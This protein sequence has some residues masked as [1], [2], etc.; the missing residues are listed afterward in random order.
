MIK[1]EA[2]IRIDKLK[3]EINHHRYLYH[4]LDTQEISDAALDSLKHELDKLEE[5]FPD[6][7]TLDSP[8]QRVGGVPLD[9]FEKV[10]HKSLMISLNDAFSPDE[11]LDWQSR[12]Q[13]LSPNTRLDYYAELKMDGFAISLI[14]K[15]G[16]LTQGS[17]RGD[18]AVGED[19]TKNLKT[20]ESIPL[21][22]EIY[23]GIHK[24]SVDFL[25][26]QDLRGEIEVRGEVYMTKQAF[27]KINKER[28]RKGEAI[29]AN[30]RNTAA[31]SIRQLNPEIAQSRELK[32]MAYALVTDLGQETHA[33]EHE[34]LG[35]L[36]FKAGMGEHCKNLEEVVKFWDK[37][38]KTRERL[39]FEIDGVV[40]NVNDNMLFKKF[41][42]VG[43]AP[44]GAIA[45]KFHGRE[46][47]TKVLDIQAQ[48][49]R[50]GALT[51][52]AILEPVEVGGVTIGRASL[53][54]QDEID[55]LDV[56]IGDTVIVRRAGDVIPDV[57]K[58]F[59]KLR[60][61]HEKKFH[62]PS[63]CPV[64][65]SKVVR[66]EGEVA[67]RCSNPE[68]GAV[69]RERLYH[70]VSKKAFNIVGLGPQRLDQLLDEGLIQDAA[71]IFDL[72]E[73]DVTSLE[74]FADR[75]A[76]NLIDSINNSKTITLPRLI[77]ALGILHIGEETAVDLA[78]QFGDI[79]KL[80]EVSFNDL[81]KVRD[82]GPVVAKSI[83][84]WFSKNKNLDFIV[85][86]KKAGVVIGKMAPIKVRKEFIGKTFVF[87]GELIQMTRDEA[88]NKVREF[89]GEVAGSVSANTDYVVAGEN[90]GSKYDKAMELGVKVI[91]EKDFL[92]M[93]K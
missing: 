36:G 59:P 57:V 46:A 67:H 84:D 3:S 9:K 71:D 28:A 50:T 89:G 77:Y 45:F 41:G 93:L 22:L 56:R 32:F 12:I 85:R 65:G 62:M 5:Q 17:T 1:I 10:K 70:F 55:R 44:R 68:C 40:V 73:G 19:V 87:T 60:T 80:P 37:I 27:A 39:P 11:M 74:R 88:R 42:V 6:L 75:S 48:V 31:G 61:G 83:A 53:H 47:T 38:G 35:A 16:L 18:G 26:E 33:Q 52:V 91:S 2:K 25:S 49:G 4:V 72:K 58:S 14:Y 92:E 24:K 54:N 63:K 76:K 90:P 86:L 29:Y 78:K 15:N 81:I 64:C 34:T 7:I 8:T 43:K 21:K 20:I 66:K 79:E 13:K 23:K 69:L 30:P 51:P 82:I